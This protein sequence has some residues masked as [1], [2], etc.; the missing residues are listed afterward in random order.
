MT[1]MQ[2]VIAIIVAIIGTAGATLG[3]VQF[4][5][6]RK[7]DKEEKDIERRIENALA[8]KRETIQADIDKAVQ[9]SIKQ[10]GEIGDKAIK[11]VVDRARNEFNEGLKMRGEEGR[12]RFETNSKQIEENTKMIREI[13]EIQKGQTKQFGEMAQSISDLAKVSEACAESQ[14]TSTYDRLLMVT[15]KIIQKG[16]MTIT[17]KTN[18]EQLYESWQKLNGHDKRIDTLYNE[19]LKK[20]TILDEQGT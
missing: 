20:E 12:Q 19:C 4:L 2:A 15:S 9:D 8:K 6:K 17:E 5:I 1:V 16:V 7:D 10:C 14:R 11:D 13:L 3:F 18:L